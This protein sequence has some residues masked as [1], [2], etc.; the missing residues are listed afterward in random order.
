MM[1]A[2]TPCCDRGMHMPRV[3]ITGATGPVGSSLA[4]Y[5]IT[6]ADV[7]LAIFKRW[8][9]DMRAVA[10]IES[11]VTFYEGDI[12]D[13]YAVTDAVA[14]FHPDFIFHL[15]AQSYPAASWGAPVATMRANVEGTVNLLEAVR[16]HAPNA[17]VH[18][19]GSSAQ[20]GVVLPEHVPIKETHPMR[21]ASPYGISKVAQELLGLQYFDS[22][23]IH[24]VVTRSFNHVGPRQ[25]DRTAIQTFCRQM[26]LI[27]VGRQ[28]PVI[29]VGNVEPRRDYTHVDDVAR[30][31][32]ALIQHAPG[33]N[34]YNMC[35]GQAVRIGDIVDMVIAR[36]QVPVE[37]RVD[38][39]RLRPVDEPILRGDNS[40]LVAV[41]GWQPR[42]SMPQIIDELL[43]YW[44]A[45]IRTE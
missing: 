7:E 38:P 10:A 29:L 33:G 26:A 12:E 13:A 3:L 5:V 35:S 30:A 24:T 15:A 14:D 2:T 43:A 11:R 28:A 25:G 1:K 39:A 31:L 19:A 6:H 27:E 20:Y 37:V 9:S 23:G 17:R 44:R 18:I 16:R 34:V 8:R 45:R 40:R 32:W 42:I 22:Y 36:G 21:P 41:T 4:E